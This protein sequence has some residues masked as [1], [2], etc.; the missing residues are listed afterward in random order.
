MSFWNLPI[1]ELVEELF[2]LNIF[3][4]MIFLLNIL[5]IQGQTIY[6]HEYKYKLL[7]DNVLPKKVLLKLEEAYPEY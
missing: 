5:T 7:L 6:N 3:T 2:I 4:A 1:V